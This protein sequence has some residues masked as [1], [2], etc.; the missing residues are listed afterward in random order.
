MRGYV[1]ECQGVEVRSMSRR[2]QRREV[3]W[4]SV[5]ALM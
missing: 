5:N 3:M 4:V 2:G 1:G